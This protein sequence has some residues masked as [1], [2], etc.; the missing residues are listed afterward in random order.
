MIIMEFKENQP[1]GKVLIELEDGT[2]ESG[3]Y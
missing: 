1:D 2:T 3:V